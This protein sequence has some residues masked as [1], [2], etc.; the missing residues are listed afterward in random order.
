MRKIIIL[1]L[2]CVSIALSQD[3]IVRVYAPA[4]KDLTKISPKYD[5][6]I[7][8][9]RANEYYDIVAD[10]DVLGQI[11]RSGLPYEIIVFSI[12][13]IINLGVYI[14]RQPNNKLGQRGNKGLEFIF[15]LVLD[16]FS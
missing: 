15:R 13:H 4:W 2:I 3:M 7:A 16:N 11:R 9:A 10:Q 5:L 8:S 6:D 14:R 12:A 1:L